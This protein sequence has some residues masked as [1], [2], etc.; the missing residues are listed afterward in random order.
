[1]SFLSSDWANINPALNP[2]PQV[3]NI[4][5][6]VVQASSFSYYTMVS[7]CLWMFSRE[8]SSTSTGGGISRL[9]DKMVAPSLALR[10]C[11]PRVPETIF[12]GGYVKLHITIIFWLF[13]WIIILCILF[14][15]LLV[16]CIHPLFADF[17]VLLRDHP[18]VS[19]I[20]PHRIYSFAISWTYKVLH[21]YKRTLFRP[22]ILCWTLPG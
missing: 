22:C 20:T 4:R 3:W 18:T 14:A 6:C 15:Y 16:F 5:K 11:K 8:S 1:M 12:W 2:A 10:E 17:N 19:S 9:I 13:L 7:A 21:T